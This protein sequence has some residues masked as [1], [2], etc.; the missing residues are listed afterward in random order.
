M[1]KEKKR[2]WGVRIQIDGLQ[3][4]AKRPESWQELPVLMAKNIQA[5]SEA[6]EVEYVEVTNGMLRLASFAPRDTEALANL[7]QGRYPAL[8]AMLRERKD[9]RLAQEVRELLNRPVEH[10]S[11]VDA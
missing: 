5:I 2:G 6:P 7:L 1:S 8:E 9:T 11:P 10:N 4:G 3:E